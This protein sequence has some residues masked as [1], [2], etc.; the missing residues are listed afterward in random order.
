[1][2]D[3]SSLQVALSFIIFMHKET[4]LTAAFA[5]PR[6]FLG[7]K[8]QRLFSSLGGSERNEVEAELGCLVSRLVAG[9][10][11]FVASFLRFSPPAA[12]PALQKLFISY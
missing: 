8:A 3:A 12:L 7:Q 9:S 2:C 10:S 11:F 5:A 6:I 4:Y 1:M